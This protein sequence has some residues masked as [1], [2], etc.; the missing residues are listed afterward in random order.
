MRFRPYTMFAVGVVLCILAALVAQLHQTISSDHDHDVKVV[1]VP[2]R[3]GSQTM[4]ATLHSLGYHPFGMADCVLRYSCLH[5]VANAHQHP[6]PWTEMLHGFDA[7]AGVPAACH[8][9]QVL[10]T[11]PNAKVIL[12]TR[13]YESWLRSWTNLWN[14]ITFF[15]DRLWFIP[16]LHEFSKACRAMIEKDFMPGG[17]PTDKD[18]FE[19]TLSNYIEKVQT[20][21]PPEHLLVIDVKDPNGLG[22]VTDFL[23]DEG[24]NEPT[25]SAGPLPHVNRVQNVIKRRVALAVLI[26]VGTLLLAVILIRKVGVMGVV[27][28]IA[29]LHGLYQTWRF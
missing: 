6:I 2:F 25:A 22:K 12:M 16:R 18:H 15:H 19:T 27:V 26:D 10:A 11:Y 7:T 24:N 8:I 29:V 9:D 3:S 21:V 13:D 5:A 14:L 28:Q 23:Y 17:S 4:K 20:M 1:V